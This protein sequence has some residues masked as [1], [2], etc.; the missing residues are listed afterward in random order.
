MLSFDIDTNPSVELTLANQL[1]WEGCPR[2]YIHM[3]KLTLK[4][5]RTLGS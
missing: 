5:Y 4:T 3:L 2:V 1:I